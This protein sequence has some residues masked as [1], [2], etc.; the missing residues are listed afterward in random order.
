MMSVSDLADQILQALGPPVDQHGKP[1]SVTAEIK[2]YAQTV[3][4]SLK[5]ALVNN[6]PGTVQAVG[7][8][9]API[10]LGSAAGGL[11]MGVSPSTWLQGLTQA[12]VGANPASLQSEAG[13]STGYLMSS[14]TVSFAPGNI[15]GQCT[16]TPTSPGPLA[17][18]AGTGG[19]VSGLSGAPW[20]GAV[21]AAL[22]GSPAP[23]ASSVYGAIA[24][25][26]DANA[27]VAYAMGSVNGAFAAGGGPMTVGVAV[28]GTIT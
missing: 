20:G 21:T 22:G 25:Y 13:A 17:S 7:A 16:A 2:G 5:A 10:T 27:Q 19:V 9:G 4:T 28:G 15:V 18:G 8:P 26:I 6:A 14:G 1:I 23:L 12:F 11:I 24:T 3:I